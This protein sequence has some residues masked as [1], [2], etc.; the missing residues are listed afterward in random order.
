[1][2]CHEKACLE[3]KVWETRAE[4]RSTLDLRELLI[5]Q[6]RLGKTPGVLSGG[7]LGSWDV[8]FPL[9]HPKGP[10]SPHTYG[11]TSSMSSAFSSLSR[12][13]QQ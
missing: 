5:P 8:Y 2:A 11:L 10:L 12:Q 7:Y 1:M 9:A 6:L 3:I 13:Q 4:L